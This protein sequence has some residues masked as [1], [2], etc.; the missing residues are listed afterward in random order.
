M[1]DILINGE[2]YRAN[3]VFKV[4]TQV[5]IWVAVFAGPVYLWI[6]RSLISRAARIAAAVFLVAY[7][8]VGAVYPAIAIDQAFTGSSIFFGIDHGL[9]W[10]KTKYPNDYAAYQYLKNIRDSF[11]HAERLK[12]IVEGEGESYTDV[13][14]FSVFLGWPTIVGWP[15]HE[16]TWRGSYDV[17]GK[18]REEVR[19]IYIGID[20]KRTRELLDRY[21]INYIILGAVE[22]DRYGTAIQEKKLRSLGAV[23]FEQGNTAV[24]NIR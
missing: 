2:W 16:W 8:G 4:A 24:I 1:K 18:R 17:V 11:P 13:S 19:E 3:T 9:D 15:V 12:R 10:W 20:Q 5:W 6:Y 7:L 14:R 22:R 21:E 23:V